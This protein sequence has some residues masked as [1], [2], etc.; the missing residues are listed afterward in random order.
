M[1]LLVFDTETTGLIKTCISPDTLS[2]LPIIVQFSYIVYDT[3][4]QDITVSRDHIIKVPEGIVIPE[5]SIQFHKI[6]NDISAKKGVPLTEVL[7][8]F[9]EHLRTVDTLIGHNVEF[10]VNMIKL[11]L[12]RFIYNFDSGLE[13]QLALYKQNLHYLT[14]FQNIYCTLKSTISFCNIKAISKFG[15]PYLK[16][17][18]L[19][20]L[21]E[22][23]FSTI[24]TNL[25]NSFNDI[26]VTLRC[27]MKFKYN[28][29]LLEPCEVFKQYSTNIGI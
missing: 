22:K 3:E 25:H 19:I 24:P 28:V 6:T 9:F 21:H 8:E 5:E 1:K 16:F 4:K 29:D 2:L 12:M 20:E 7:N 18:K 15:K 11:E 27:F 14:N 26:L 10:D 23:L 13:D 17:P